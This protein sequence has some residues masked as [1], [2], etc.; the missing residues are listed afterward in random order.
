MNPEPIHTV[1][2]VLIRVKNTVTLL[3]SDG[4]FATFDPDLSRQAAEA[5]VPKLQDAQETA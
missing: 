5:A 1:D 3:V 2:I 4:F